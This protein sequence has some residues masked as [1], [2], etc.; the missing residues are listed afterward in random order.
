MEYLTLG[1]SFISWSSSLNI[2]WSQTVLWW[3]RF[4][5]YILW[6]KISKIA[7]KSPHVC[8]P[9]SSWPEVY[10]LSCHLLEG[11]LLLL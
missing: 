6:Q 4:M 9:I 11:T 8:Y 2:G 5:K 10:S 1:V 7:A 3:N